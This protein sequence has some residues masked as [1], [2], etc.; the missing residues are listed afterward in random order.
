MLAPLSGSAQSPRTSTKS[1]LS[2][3][4]F[5][6]IK[7][8]SWDSFQKSITLTARINNLKR[9]LEREGKRTC[10][11]RKSGTSQDVAPRTGLAGTPQGLGQSAAATNLSIAPTPPKN[12]EASHTSGQAAD[13]RHQKR[14]AW[15]P[16]LE[17]AIVS[18][19][20]SQSVKT[21]A[22]RDRDKVPGSSLASSQRVLGSSL[23]QYRSSPEIFSPNI[24]RTVGA[25]P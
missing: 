21:E 24:A 15:R 22:C 18:A 10:Q 16:R 13:A 6:N 4:A 1:F 7:N 5:F 23:V 17:V 3:S 2:L 20:W 12:H 19:C 11:K 14:V 25:M 9:S 8:E